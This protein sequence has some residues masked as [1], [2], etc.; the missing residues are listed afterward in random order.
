MGNG[1]EIRAKAYY[2][3]SKIARTPSLLVIAYS[4]RDFA[5]QTRAQFLHFYT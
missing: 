4:T 1:A 5:E 3:K 2:V